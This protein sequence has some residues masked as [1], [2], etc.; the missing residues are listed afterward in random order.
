MVTES[1]PSLTTTSTRWLE[2]GSVTR[3]MFN[4]SIGGIGAITETGA[5]GDDHDK[6]SGE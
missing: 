4:T 1:G 2:S 3:W 5:S 6:D